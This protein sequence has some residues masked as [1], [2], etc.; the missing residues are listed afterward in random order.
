MLGT[1]SQVPTRYRNHNGYFL[2]WDGEGLLFDPGEGTQRQMT[3]AGLSATQITRICV[4][5]FHGDHALG[6]AGIL[7]R[8]S[9]DRVPHP[10]HV[11][12]PASGQRYFDRLRTSTIYQDHAKLVLHPLEADGPADE[13]GFPLHS[14]RLEHGVDAVGYRLVEPDGRRMS[15]ERLAAAGV[16]GADVGRVL[17]EGHVETERGRVGLGEV[18]DLRPGQRFAFVMDT[19]PCE[20]ARRLAE[21]A[22][23][24]V[25][26]AT[27]LDA[28]A[29]EARAHGHMTARQ[30]AELARDAGARRLLLTHFSQRYPNTDGH[31]REAAEVF[32]EALAAEDLLVV[33]LPPRAGSA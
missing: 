16:R 20:G 9:L 17:R 4:T 12:Y 25:C 6:L 21:G 5:H 15:P 32:P 22:D 23:L 31:L 29:A 28:E 26:E 10:V 7:Q 8:I 18:S 19:R 3:L 2:R 33:P 13:D 14:A 27:Y 24:L 30:A 1:A 11:Y